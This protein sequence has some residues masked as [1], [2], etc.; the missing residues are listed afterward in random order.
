MTPEVDTAIET[1]LTT[2]Y[3]RS[4]RK[5]NCVALVSIESLDR[6]NYLLRSF[7]REQGSD[8]LSGVDYQSR[9]P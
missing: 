1:A 4:P 6:E 3:Q 5:P 8:Y 7:L 9:L 2:K